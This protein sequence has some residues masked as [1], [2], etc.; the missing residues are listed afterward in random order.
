LLHIQKQVE[1]YFGDQN[2]PKDKFLKSQA[3]KD[4]KGWVPISVVLDFKRMK[5]LT[6]DPQDVVDALKTSDI[7]DIDAEKKMIKRKE[8]ALEEGVSD[9]TL[10]IKGW[11]TTIKIEEVTEVCSKL[12]LVTNV[13]IRRRADKT[14]KPSCWV[15][16]ESEEKAKEIAEKQK[17]EFNG[18]QLLILT[19]D[20]YLKAKDSE[21]EYL[22]TRKRKR[23]SE[24]K[25]KKSEEKRK[26]KLEEI[27]NENGNETT[28]TTT[29]T[30][31]LKQEEEEGP[32]KKKK[33]EKKK[34]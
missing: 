6:Q 19:K 11:P 14:Q 33:K 23:G 5:N 1:F 13:K 9:K 32:S 31:E 24:K 29:T 4:E 26:V 15:E 7:V 18:K 3:A 28:T 25:D 22:A 8:M 20:G 16:F 2:Y 10:F 34:K 21:K 27:K 12:G 17:L 30:N